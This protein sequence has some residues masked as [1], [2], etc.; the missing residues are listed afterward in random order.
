VRRTRNP[1]P[2]IKAALRAVHRLVADGR[3]YDEVSTALD[4]VTTTPE[5]SGP[6]AAMLIALERIDLVG[7]YAV[8]DTEVERVLDSTATEVAK[9]PTH[10][11]AWLLRDA[12][13][14]RRALAERYLAPMLADLEARQPGDWDRLTLETLRA[15]LSV[16]R[17]EPQEE[18]IEDEPSARMEPS[19]VLAGVR[20]VYRLASMGWP[21]EDVVVALDEVAA[22]PV[23]A[24][25]TG[26]LARE[27][28]ILANMYERPDEEVESAIE[29]AM[30]AFRGAGEPVRQW[31][32]TITAACMGRPALAKKYVPPL[33]VEFEEELRQRPDE[34]GERIL[35]G[36]KQGLERTARPADC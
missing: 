23:A 30:H 34:V 11:R 20:Y 22:L 31:A 17:G 14:G 19:E 6:D 2:V 8:D 27:R 12:C 9:L 36:I 29:A 16:A 26:W 32:G 7:Q 15:A 33:I 21:Y 25:A 10:Q 5:A 28:L 13:W 18:D 35:E 24:K 3:P 1:P 4:A